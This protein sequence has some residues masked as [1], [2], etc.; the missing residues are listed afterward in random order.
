MSDQNET[1]T[2]WTQQ[3]IRGRERRKI[4]LRQFND[5]T[6]PLS[7]TQLEELTGIDRQIV[8]Q[9]IQTLLKQ[10]HRIQRKPAN[11]PATGNKYL[12]WMEQEDER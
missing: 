2:E 8:S 1:M 5:T 4:I 10:G 6:D 11:D 3:R 12:Y 7:V 9:C